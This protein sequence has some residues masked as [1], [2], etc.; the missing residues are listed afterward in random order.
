MA[1]LYAPQPGRRTRT[2]LSSK[3]K[4]GQRFLREQSESVRDNVS[5]AFGRGRVAV[6]KSMRGFMG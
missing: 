1:L 5:E 2:M 4:Q 6:S 3:S